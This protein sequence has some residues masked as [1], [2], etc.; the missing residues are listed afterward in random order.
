MILLMANK[1]QNVGYL[2]PLNIISGVN[3]AANL[4]T[5]DQI[6]DDVRNWVNQ[7]LVARHQP[8]YSLSSLISA[9][10]WDSFQRELELNDYLLRDRI[11][12]LIPQE[13]WDND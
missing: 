2:L 13:R 7:G 12:D 5:I 6:F 1:Y 9:R 10:E 11:G 8:I 4:Y 3:M